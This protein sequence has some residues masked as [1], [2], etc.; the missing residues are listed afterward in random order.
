M[1]R[2]DIP[3]FKGASRGIIS[4]PI[5]SVFQGH[6]KDGLGDSELLDRSDI[7]A[8]GEEHAIFKII[9]LV[10]AHPN[11][12]EFLMLGPLTNLAMA[13]R[14]DPSII[15]LIKRVCIMGG[16][17]TATGNETSAA[18][19]NFY[20]DPEAAAIIFEAFSTS[21]SSKL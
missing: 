4:P 14:L 20:C 6:G 1:D 13:V 15:P 16:T 17:D 21:E 5:V 11:E 19:F 12:I 10:K 3:Y 18:E 2:S 7:P 9:E 8:H